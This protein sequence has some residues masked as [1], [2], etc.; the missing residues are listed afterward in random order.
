MADSYFLGCADAMPNAA[1]TVGRFHV[2]RLFTR[3]TDRARVAEAKSS[4]EKRALF[5]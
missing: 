5:S 3:A 1:R 2:M 4:A